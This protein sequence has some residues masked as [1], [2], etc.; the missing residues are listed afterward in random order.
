M[1]SV[2]DSKVY[3]S[4]MGITK[5][6]GHSMSGEFCTNNIDGFEAVLRKNDFQFES[7]FT[8]ECKY[9]CYFLCIFPAFHVV[10]SLMC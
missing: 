6:Y 9:C 7:S 8:Q 5:G 1:T 4:L 3:S 10:K 2:A